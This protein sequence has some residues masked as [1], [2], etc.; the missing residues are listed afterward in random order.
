[1][2]VLHLSRSGRKLAYVIWFTQM[3]R[4]QSKSIICAK[5][6]L[7]LLNYAGYKLSEGGALF[8]ENITSSSQVRL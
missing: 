1:M 4:R 8:S 5:A 7:K 6:Y 2:F 3:P